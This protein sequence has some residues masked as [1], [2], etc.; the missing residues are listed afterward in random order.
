MAMSDAVGAAV[1]LAGLYFELMFS[2]MSPGL[3]P[4]VCITDNHSLLDSLKSSKMVSEKRLRIELSNIKH[5][6][7]RGQVKSVTWTETK[8]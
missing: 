5:M 3:S 2:S 8:K 6:V 4:I 1:F 7:D